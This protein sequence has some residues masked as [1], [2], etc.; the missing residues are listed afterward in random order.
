MNIHVRFAYKKDEIDFV[1]NDDQSKT[2]N[3]I[4]KLK[5]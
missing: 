2:V 4:L 5:V 3:L 1:T